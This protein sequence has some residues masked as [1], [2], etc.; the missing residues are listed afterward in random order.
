MKTTRTL[1]FSGS[2]QLLCFS[3]S[4]SRGHIVPGRFQKAR[5]LFGGISVIFDQ[6]NA[7]G[8]RGGFTACVWGRFCGISH[9]R[10]GEHG[11]K[12]DC[13]LRS[14]VPSF[15]LGGYRSAM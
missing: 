10:R 13:E 9:N 6:Q 3:D 14:F 15:A 11:V 12:T 1:L 7:K 2:D 4:A 8:T 5:Q